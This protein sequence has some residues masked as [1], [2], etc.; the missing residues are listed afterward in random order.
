MKILK[1]RKEGI[2]DG[3]EKGTLT[4]LLGAADFMCGSRVVV[5]VGL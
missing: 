4:K 3:E 1:M 5:L 2:D